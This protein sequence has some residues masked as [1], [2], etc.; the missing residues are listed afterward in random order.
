M[1]IAVTVD[2][3]QPVGPLWLEVETDRDAAPIDGD[4][5]PEFGARLRRVAAG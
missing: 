3:S 5:A 1:H 4:P 2:A